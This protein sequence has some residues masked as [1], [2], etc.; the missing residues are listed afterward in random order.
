MGVA[1]RCVVVQQGAQRERAVEEYREPVRQSAGIGDA[2]LAGGLPYQLPEGAFVLGRD[3]PELLDPP[4]PQAARA[5]TATRSR[6]MRAA[7]RTAAHL[8]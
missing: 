6:E 8:I 5:R 1:E 7:L 3:P 4:P 2:G